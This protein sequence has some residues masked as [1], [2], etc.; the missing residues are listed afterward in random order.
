[1][2]RFAWIAVGLTAL[3]GCAGPT[4]QYS[5]SPVKFPA[6]AA[7]F[8]RP[9]NL[10]QTILFRPAKGDGPF[11][12]VVL[13]HTCGGVGRHLYDWAQRLTGDGYVAMI[14]DGV[15]PRNLKDNCLPAWQAALSL[16]QYNRDLVAG[17]AHLRSLPFVDGDA[18]AIAGYSFGAIASIKL[19]SESYRRRIPDGGL[20]GL[21]ALA[22]F[23]GSCAT[24]SSNPQAQ[25]AY[26]WSTDIVV[27]VIAF[28][29][30]IDNEAPAKPC[31]AAAE[32]AGARTGRVT[33]KVYPNTTHA[34]DDPTHGTQG[35]QIYHGARGPFLYRYNPEATEDAWRTMKALFDRELKRT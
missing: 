23:Y 17:L 20:D 8:H 27:P 22:F 4:I 6:E 29:G 32:R 34:F 21:K 35:R 24:D 1:M 26:A 33:Y 13:A 31:A 14:V 11:P 19:A 7:T 3:S 12:A 5:E 10:K 2:V 28:F 18:L 16:D 30:E 15:S 9:S 25:A